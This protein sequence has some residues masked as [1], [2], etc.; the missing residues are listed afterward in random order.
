MDVTGYNG[1]DFSS[2]A[3]QV[4]NLFPGFMIMTRESEQRFQDK[5]FPP[6]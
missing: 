5:R 2:L 3:D 6:Y 4:I 1:Y